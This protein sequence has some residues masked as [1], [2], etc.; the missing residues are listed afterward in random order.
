[1][2]VDIKKYLALEESQ[3]L[4]CGDSINE[5][6]Y[7]DECHGAFELEVELRSEDSFESALWEKTR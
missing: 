5:E 1:M 6:G 3:C 4:V 7:C 2:S